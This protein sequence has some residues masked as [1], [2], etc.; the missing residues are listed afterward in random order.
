MYYI[1]KYK[2]PKKLKHYGK[3]VIHS[4]N[5]N[6]TEVYLARPFMYWLFKKRII[7]DIVTIC[8]GWTERKNMEII[9]TV[10]R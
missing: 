3:F 7:K 4:W 10:K 1:A 2:K 9:K 5:K 6:F 8:L